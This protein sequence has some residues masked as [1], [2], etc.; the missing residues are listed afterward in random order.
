MEFNSFGG[1]KVFNP[2]SSYLNKVLSMC[3]TMVF[4]VYEES[5]KSIGY[6]LFLSAFPSNFKVL[7]YNE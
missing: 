2:Y 7:W 3:V 4:N 6:R 5:S 1:I